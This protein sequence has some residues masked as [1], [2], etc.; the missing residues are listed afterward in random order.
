[1]VFQVIFIDLDDTL[2]SPKTGL[3]QMIKD[4]I[5]LYMLEKMGMEPGSISSIRRELFEKYG[6]TMRGLQQVYGVDEKEYLRFVHDVPVE[7]ILTKDPGL[8]K[9]LGRIPLKKYIFTNADIDHATRILNHLEVREYFHGIIDIIAMSPH[10]KPQQA[11]FET[12]MKIA[13]VRSPGQCIL[14]DDSVNNTRV[15]K[16]LGMFSVLV[17]ENGGRADYDQKIPDIRHLDDVIMD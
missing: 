15:A 5:E 14:V 12:A 7:A 17:S 11:A 10:C 13:V 3:W 4:R 2:Y 16:E 9:I 6:T 1:M 8:Q